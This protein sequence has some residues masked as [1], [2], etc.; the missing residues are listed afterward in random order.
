MGSASRCSSATHWARGWDDSAAF[1]EFR[2]IF[3]RSL[4]GYPDGSDF[5]NRVGE[6]F[7]GDFEGEVAFP[8]SLLGGAGER[9]AEFTELVDVHGSP[10]EAW[11]RTHGLRSFP[12]EPESQIAHPRRMRSG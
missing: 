8:D 4:E 10:A 9:K 12:A 11:L 7:V 1:G 6:H 5:Q 3:G 2:E